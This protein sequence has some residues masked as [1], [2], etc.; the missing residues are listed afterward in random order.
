MSRKNTKQEHWIQKLFAELT[1]GLHSL[2]ELKQMMREDGMSGKT[3]NT[4][5]KEV[6]ERIK[7]EA[8][9]LKD[10]SYDLNLL[11]LYDI[12]DTANQPTDMISAL[13]KINKMTGSYTTNINI[14]DKIR[15]ILG[16]EE[17][18][19]KNFKGLDEEE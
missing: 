5:I 6:K 1:G 17:A 2:R 10:V 13:D 18:F 8:N 11:K 3:I 12:V 14:Q 4:C 7:N 9:D 15:F 16:D 19:E